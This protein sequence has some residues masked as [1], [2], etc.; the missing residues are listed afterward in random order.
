M[1][2]VHSMVPK[3]QSAVI[4]NGA[5]LPLKLFILTFFFSSSESPTAFM[6]MIVFYSEAGGRSSLCW[7][8]LHR[9]GARGGRV[10]RPA[11]G[12]RPR[13]GGRSG[14]R[15]A[16]GPRAAQVHRWQMEPASGTLSGEMFF[17]LIRCV[18]DAIRPQYQSSYC[19]RLHRCRTHLLSR[20]SDE[21]FGDKKYPI[22]EW[23]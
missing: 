5:G 18:A 12:R 9:P 13:L 17:L 8:A 7:M 16:R 20:G 23:Q 2:H 19:L 3:Q 11:R 21:L 10:W 14:G 4:T 22:H 15:G 1:S 6:M